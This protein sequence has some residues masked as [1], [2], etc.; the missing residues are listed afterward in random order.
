MSAAT[1][2]LWPTKTRD[3]LNH[4]QDST[5]WDSITLREGDVVAANWAKAGIT[6]LQQIIVQLLNDGGPD[7]HCGGNVVWP[8][9]WTIDKAQLRE[10]T[11]SI[12]GRRVFKCHLPA[13]SLNLSPLARYIYIGRDAR[14][15]VWSLHPHIWNYTQELIDVVNRAPH[16]DWPDWPG[17]AEDIHRF[18]ADWLERD[19][20]PYWSFWSNVQS[21]WDVRHL[22]NVMLVHHQALA[23][24]R[25]G[26]IRRI[27]DFLGVEPCPE[28]WGRILRHTSFDWMKANPDRLLPIHSFKDQGASFMNK[29]VNGRWRDVLSSAEIARCDEEAARNLTPG[30]ARW[31]ATG[32]GEA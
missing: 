18:Y 5:N 4:H 20:H 25:E 27:A 31:L 16:R 24:D 8:D 28:A 32:E 6:W 26:Q 30:C 13:D 7:V 29:G 11:D 14:D 17:A 9:W 19:G 23:A 15:V 1:D 3:V 10:W 12:P 22:P 2:T 21:W